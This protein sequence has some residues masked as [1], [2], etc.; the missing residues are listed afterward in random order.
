MQLYWVG[1]D[2]YQYADD[3]E[4]G[5]FSASV[6]AAAMGLNVVFMNAGSFLSSPYSSLIVVVS[7]ENDPCFV[8]LVSGILMVVFSII[9]LAVVARIRLLVAT[10]DLSN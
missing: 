5:G 9:M 6:Y 1:G 10:T 8:L 7:R 2:H 4:Y 3:P